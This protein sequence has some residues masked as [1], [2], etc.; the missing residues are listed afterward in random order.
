ML[1]YL[2]LLLTFLLLFGVSFYFAFREWLRPQDDAP[3]PV[4][5][6]Y[7]RVENYFGDSFRAKMQLWLETSRPVALGVPLQSPIQGVLEKSN[8]ERILLLNPGRYGGG[9]E[10][11]TLL[12]CDG[13]LELERG[14][15]FAREIYARGD[16]ETGEGVQLQALASDGDVA[17]G[18][19][20][21]VARW[22]D[23]AGSI[24]LRRGTV[25]HARVSSQTVIQLEAGAAAQSLYA[26]LVHT[27]GYRPV[28]SYSAPAPRAE[29]SGTLTDAGEAALANLP[30]PVARL[31]ADTVLVRGDLALQPGTRIASHLIVRGTLRTGADCAFFGDVKAERLE[32]GPGNAVSGN[33]VSGSALRLGTGCRVARAVVA[34]TDIVLSSGVRV[35]QPGALAVVSAGGEIRLEPDV[36]VWGKIAAGT[37][38]TAV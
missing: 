10:H 17:L 23:A 19:D 27:A 2:I 24:L 20:T 25:A 12:C 3:I 16:V 7:V 22:V 26:P 4:D 1:G 15:V 8:G 11:Q 29:D 18:P 33:L 5:V 34:E 21:Q 31:A 30:T 13:N 32:L 9:G 35:G 37:K 6:E 38:V 14:S 36:A 28:E